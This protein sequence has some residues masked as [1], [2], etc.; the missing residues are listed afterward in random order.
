MK[1]ENP[2]KFFSLLNWTEKFLYC[3]TFKIFKIFDLFVEI[4]PNNFL[5]FLLNE[6]EYFFKELSR[7]FY[8]L[9]RTTIKLGHM[10]IRSWKNVNHLRFQIVRSSKKSMHEKYSEVSYRHTSIFY[11]RWCFS[12]IDWLACHKW[13]N[14]NDKTFSMS[15]SCGSKW[16]FL[17]VTKQ[18]VNWGEKIYRFFP[19]HTIWSSFAHKKWV[20][21]N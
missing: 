21:S 13:V 19:L 18:I 12:S 2:W 8:A 14:F 16:I 4:F 5:S 15:F 9:S 20:E 7:I 6:L 11:I 10:S 1:L 17:C 3:K